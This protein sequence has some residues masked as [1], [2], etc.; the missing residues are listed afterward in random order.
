MHTRV[1]IEKKP[2][3]EVTHT[4]INASVVAREREIARQRE[5]EKRERHRDGR[6]EY[7]HRARR[8][9]PKAGMYDVLCNVCHHN[10]CESDD[11]VAPALR[12]AM[13]LVNDRRLIKR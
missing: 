2:K 7:N 6:E 4:S 1:Q 5:R 11:A 10:A 13:Y 8:V 9:Q 3:T 12:T